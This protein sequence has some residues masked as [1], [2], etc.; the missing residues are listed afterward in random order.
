MEIRNT[1]DEPEK[2]AL[3]VQVEL[4]SLNGENE[5]VLYRQ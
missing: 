5:I 3:Y 4:Y 1:E 2:C